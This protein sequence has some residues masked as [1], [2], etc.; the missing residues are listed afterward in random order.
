MKI[1]MFGAGA[2]GGLIGTRLALRGQVELSA[3]ARGAT[4]QALRQHGWRLHS[5]GQRAGVAAHASDDAREL[6]VQDVV[7]IAVKAPSMAQVAA[8]IGPLLGAHTIVVPAINGVPWWFTHSLAG[9]AGVD[10]P[11][12]SLDPQGRIAAAIEVRRVIGCVVHASAAAPQPGLVEH[13]GGN[14][15]ILGELDGV[16]RPRLAALVDVFA[17]AGFEISRSSD[18]RR[19][20]WFKLWGN[21]TMNPVSALTGATADRILDDALVRDFCSAAMAEAAAIGVRIGCAI[22]QSPDERHRLT[23]QLGALETSMLQD[24][25]SGRA[26]EIDAIVA[27]VRELG[28]RVGVATPCI[29]ALLGLG[30]LFARVRGLY[31]AA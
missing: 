28:Q 8:A 29:D 6:G 27:A 20:V 10:A 25:R 21:L 18:I 19:D 4:L 11:L 9:P 3:L 7:V 26:L 2:I 17:D 1:C 24:V 30:R 12:Q 13:R 31:P 5:Q 22:T 16:A 23:R 14:G 15:L